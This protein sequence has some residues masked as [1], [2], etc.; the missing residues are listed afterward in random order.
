MSQKNAMLD[1]AIVLVNEGYASTAVGPIEVFSAAASYLKSAAAGA[2]S[3]PS[4]SITC[5]L[6]WQTFA[7]PRGRVLLRR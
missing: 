7:P 5:P 2:R 4:P 3:V 1:V 6:W